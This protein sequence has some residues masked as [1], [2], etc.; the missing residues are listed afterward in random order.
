MRISWGK[1]CWIFLGTAVLLAD[2]GSSMTSG[3]FEYVVYVGD[4]GGAEGHGN[5]TVTVP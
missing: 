3:T 2:A 4:A 1:A 5:F